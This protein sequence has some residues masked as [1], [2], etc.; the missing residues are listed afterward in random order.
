[1]A[2][3]DNRT[4]DRLCEERALLMRRLAGGM[5]HAVRNP[6][7]GI[8][9]ST[10]LLIRGLDLDN[11]RAHKRLLAAGCSEE[12]IERFKG[13]LGDRE[14]LRLCELVTES[15]Q[16]LMSLLMPFLEMVRSEQK[17][18]K[19]EMDL[20]EALD[21]ALIL[22]RHELDLKGVY[23]F[24]EVRIDR[25]G[26]ARPLMVLL[27]DSMFVQALLMLFRPIADALLKRRQADETFESVLTVRAGK[28]GETIW[29][30][31]E[32]RGETLGGNPFQAEGDPWSLDVVRTIVEERHRGKVVYG[33]PA[34]GGNL[35]RL[36]L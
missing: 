15:T 27:D 5:P 12:E 4:D 36:E 30:E 1:M 18:M 11:Q 3:D 34:E 20:G 7:A 23:R 2:V 24:R 26:V 31:L 32:D 13:Y 9:Q 17:V 22:S 14:L 19:R 21:E 6:I 16:Q 33:S 25:E 28:E 35:W 8:S 29:L 10:Q